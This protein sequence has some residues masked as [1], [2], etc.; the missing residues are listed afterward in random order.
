LAT[1]EVIGKMIGIAIIPVLTRIYSPEDFGVLSVFTAVVSILAP[2][3]TFRYVLA[4]PLPKTDAMAFNIFA[5][6]LFF[7]MVMTTILSLILYSFHSEILTAIDQK[8][9]IQYWWLV[10]LGV[11]IV[12]LYELLVYWATRKKQ[13][14]IIS[15]SL[16]Y[17]NLIGSTA[18]VVMGLM[19]LKSLGLLCGHILQHG[20]GGSRLVQIMR[21][22][23]LHYKSRVNLKNIFFVINYYRQF[24]I[25]RLPSQFILLLSSQL[26]I[27]YVVYKYGTE[28]GGQFGLALMVLGLP[29]QVLSQTIGRVYYAEIAGIGPKRPLIILDLTSVVVKRLFFIG[30]VPV[31]ILFVF[32][33]QIFDFC[34]GEHWLEAG[35]FASDMALYLFFQLIVTPIVNIFSVFNKHVLFLLVNIFRLLILI[36]LF[37]LD[38]IY[39]FNVGEL[40]K[41]YSYSLASFYMTVMVV[42]F[43]FLFKIKQGLNR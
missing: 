26:P 37:F 43:V 21:A 2:I 36:T 42:V 9:I 34:F 10:P 28:L 15:K 38:Y 5:V 20:T 23:Y 29:V 7:I 33:T 16:I 27:L 12:S 8:E 24:P 41:T 32:G 22:P 19:D 30:V 3:M 25:Y 31:S 14:S 35:S 11:F 4:I 18:K 40:V 6:S 39:S 13:F 17:Q 1:G